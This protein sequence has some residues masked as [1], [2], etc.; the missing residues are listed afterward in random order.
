M[1]RTEQFLSDLDE[2]RKGLPRHLKNLY[3]QADSVD[4]FIRKYPQYAQRI[5]AH[6]AGRSVTQD[7]ASSYL[8]SQMKAGRG[9]RTASRSVPGFDQ[10]LQTRPGTNLGGEQVPLIP[11]SKM[12]QQARDSWRTKNL[13][14]MNNM[15]Q[16][17]R[18]SYQKWWEQ[19]APATQGS[20]VA[21]LPTPVNV[22]Q[23][24]TPQIQLSPAQ[25]ASAQASIARHAQQ[26]PAFNASTFRASPQHNTPLN[27]NAQAHVAAN[28]PVQQAQAPVAQVVNHPPPAVHPSPAPAVQPQQHVPAARGNQPQQRNNATRNRWLRN[29]IGASLGIGAAGGAG[30]WYYQNRQPRRP[31]RKQ[32]SV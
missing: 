9:F 27:T 25:R 28:Q 30:A 8:Q 32:W 7:A 17:R 22:V 3:N 23:A 31:P 2:V 6:H 13:P 19:N 14:R 15:R 10:R 11:P 24:I 21:S 29:S 18:A 26:T 20:A 16:R 1:T 12:S 4:D 5:Q